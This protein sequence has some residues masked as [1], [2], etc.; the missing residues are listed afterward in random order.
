MWTTLCP[1]QPKGFLIKR[2]ELVK[3]GQTGKLFMKPKRE[4]EDKIT[5]RFG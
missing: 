2:N 3:H 5:A 4:T 1:I